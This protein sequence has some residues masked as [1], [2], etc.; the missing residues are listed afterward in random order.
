MLFEAL[1][2]VLSFGLREQYPSH[3]IFFTFVS[4]VDV[5]ALPKIHTL[6]DLPIPN[7]IIDNIF[8]YLS[9]LDLLNLSIVGNERLRE[10][11]CKLL[12]KTPRGMYSGLI[13]N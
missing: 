8:T 4:F 9:S 2:F 6:L 13:I 12:R 10:C 1:H 7:E 11:S 5:V 3:Q